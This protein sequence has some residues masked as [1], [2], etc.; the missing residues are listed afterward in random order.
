MIVEFRRR[1]RRTS[2][3]RL[4]VAGL[5]IGAVAFAALVFMAIASAVADL[6]AKAFA[7]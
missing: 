4:V 1:R 7:S 3:G 6:A 2:A 5:R